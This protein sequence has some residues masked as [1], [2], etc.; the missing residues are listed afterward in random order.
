M[1]KVDD[2]TVEGEAKKCD[3]LPVAPPFAFTGS[4]TVFQAAV[5]GG[6][7]LTREIFGDPVDDADLATKASD[8]DTAKCQLEML[9]QAN[10]LED[11]VLKEMNKAKR[12]AIQQ[13]TVD[14]ASALES[15]LV[16]ALMRVPI[17]KVGEK[18]RK[19]EER[20]EKRVDKKCGELGPP[21]AIFPGECGVGDPSLAD[22]EACVIAAARCQ[23][24]LKIEAFDGLDLPCDRLDD[25]SPNW[26]CP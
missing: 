11:T 2:K 15:V 23:A 22:V 17:T 4:T 16:I 8:K 7:A 3:S 21:N 10:K 14:S 5:D 1:Q 13:E 18:L 6:Q 26:S 20:L 25:G 12:S 9:K 19:A 24:C